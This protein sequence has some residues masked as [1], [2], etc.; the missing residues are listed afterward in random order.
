[1]TGGT[2]KSHLYT[3]IGIRTCMNGTR[4]KF[5]RTAALVNELIYAKAN[6]I[7]NKLLKQMEKIY[8]LIRDEC[9]H[10]PTDVE[11]VKLLYRVI[12]GYY[13]RKCIV[14]T[15]NLEFSK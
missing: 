10:I 3:A 11:R 6:E 7:S 8:L 15:T 9:S 12:F 1:M 5:C 2:I 14:L 13:K 4:V